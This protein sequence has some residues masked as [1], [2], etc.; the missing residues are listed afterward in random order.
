MCQ[1]VLRQSRLYS[2]DGRCAGLDSQLE[3]ESSCFLCD[4]YDHPRVWTTRPG[5]SKIENFIESF[6]V[7]LD[8]TSICQRQAGNKYTGLIIMASLVC[9]EPE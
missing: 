9:L 4:Q 2:V 1:L 5:R 8:I 6:N 3:N 7:S